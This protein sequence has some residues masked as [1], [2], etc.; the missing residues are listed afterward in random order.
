MG[1]ISIWI[2]ANAIALKSKR[3]VEEVSV[4]GIALISF[5]YLLMGTIGILKVG[6]IIAIGITVICLFYC[7]G[8]LVLNF[9]NTIGTLVSVGSIGLFA[10]IVFF[11]LIY[12]GCGF[13]H[14]DNLTY[15]GIN[16]KIL[17][18]TS[19]L[20]A[21][22]RS[23]VCIH[24]EGLIVWD[25][26]ILKT[27]VGYTESLPLAFHSII[28]V[29]L[30]M[31]FFKFA[32][33]RYKYLKGLAIWILLLALPCSAYCGY[34][35]ILGDVPLAL[36]YVYC[37]IALLDYVKTYEKVN[38]IQI[39]CG[40]YIILSTKRGGLIVAICFLI[41]TSF[42]LLQKRYNEEKRKR[43][44]EILLALLAETLVVNTLW[45]AKFNVAYCLAIIGG[46]VA[47]VILAII[48]DNWAK[49]PAKDQIFTGFII[50]SIIFFYAFIKYYLVTDDFTNKIASNY[51]IWILTHESGYF[52]FPIALILVAFAI[53]IIE[54]R[55]RYWQD[56]SYKM[57]VLVGVG[58]IISASA[59]LFIYL[60]L[61]VKQ[62]G[63]ANGDNG[64]F[65]PSFS[66]YM[67]PIVYGIV[68]YIYYL[69]LDSWEN[70][71]REA[72][73]IMSATAVLY[74]STVV[75]M[76]F[77][78]NEPVEF[79]G[80]EQAGIELTQEDDLL[81]VLGEIKSD[82]GVEWPESFAYAMS[83]ATTEDIFSL[84]EV[85]PKSDSIEDWPTEEE[86]KKILKDNEIDYI[87]IQHFSD[88]FK[89]LYMDMF[90][91]LEDFHSGMVYKVDYF[92]DDVE[93]QLK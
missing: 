69:I 37:I 83:P 89:E 64:P 67:A 52:N 5:A 41:C 57:R 92:G 66:R 80:F 24:P 46:I 76:V 47:G 88:E 70:S 13:T 9:K 17:Y 10:Y 31:P 28:D 22:T 60:V 55:K 20:R 45:I 11:A 12:R 84:L 79:Y 78:K 49:I 87:Y 1:I 26:Y 19:M 53:I 59:F 27:W 35:S 54:I 81:V 29:V 93:V 2:I 34:G 14:A 18:N 16:I 38:V 56:R 50:L 68:I 36:G 23:F 6:T 77:I 62:I 4:F 65:M 48:A 51:L 85:D 30:V 75:S 86:F 90:P 73:F 43:N 82:N 3:K 40:L 32:N 33:G 71:K 42:V 74:I 61:Y 39:I 7:L 72:V 63:P 91:G 44:I 58:N 8:K 21:V 25:Y 15:W